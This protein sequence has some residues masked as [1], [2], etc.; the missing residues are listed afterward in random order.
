MFIYFLFQAEDGIRDYKV[1]GVQTCALPISPTVPLAR[2]LF[3]APTRHYKT[4]IV[5]LAWLAGHQDHFV[6]VG[7]AQHDR[8]PAQLAALLPLAAAAGVLP[9]PSLAARRQA[10]FLA[11]AGVRA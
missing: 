1:T 9:D 10:E 8:D 11:A 2:H 5:Y 7:G 3:A 6:M 4:G